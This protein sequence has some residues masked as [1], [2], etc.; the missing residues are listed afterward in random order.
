MLA[1]VVLLVLALVSGAYYLRFGGRVLSEQYML[2]GKVE[3]VVELW[4]GKVYIR[5]LKR[6]QSKH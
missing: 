6:E 3:Q 4:N 2:G 5:V 1:A